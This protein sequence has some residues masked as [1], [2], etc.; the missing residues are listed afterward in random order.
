MFCAGPL[1]KFPPGKQLGS[2]L[3]RFAGWRYP[4]A[5]Q[6]GNRMGEAR[7]RQSEAHHSHAA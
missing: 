2:T 4:G 6:P 3:V 7:R 1:P 5:I